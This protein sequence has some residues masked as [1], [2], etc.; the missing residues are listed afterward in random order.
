MFLVVQEA[1]DAAVRERKA[2]Q[3]E[4]NEIMAKQQQEILA[5]EETAYNTD[6]HLVHMR[7]DLEVV[8]CQAKRVNRGRW[9]AK[10]PCICSFTISQHPSC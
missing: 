5:W 4:L 8:P 7:E 9:G 3:E 1:E 6:A 2:L 10:S